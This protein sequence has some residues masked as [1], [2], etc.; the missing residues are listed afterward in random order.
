M[1]VQVAGGIG[2]GPVGLVRRRRDSMGSLTMVDGNLVSSREPAARQAFDRAMLEPF[3]CGRD[4]A[5][6]AA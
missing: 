6:Q 4:R 5:H 2:G 3:G 1:D